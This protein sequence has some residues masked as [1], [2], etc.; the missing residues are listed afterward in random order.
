MMRVTMKKL[1]MAAALAALAGSAFAAHER[2]QAVKDHLEWFKDQKFGL[3]MHFGLYSQLGIVESWPLV[4]ADASWSRFEIANMTGDALRSMYFGMNRSFNPVLFDPKEWADAAVAGGFKYVIFTTKHHDGFCLY[5]TKYTDFKTTDASC[6][7]SSNANANLVKRLFDACR[8]RGL[9]I[10][11]YFSKADWHCTDYWENHGIGYH[12]TR[13]PTYDPRK[14]PVKWGRFRDFT[15]NQMVELARDCG[16]LDM[17]WLDAGWCGP[18]NNQN[19][20][21]EGTMAE[22]RKYSPGVLAIGLDSDSPCDDVKVV[23][24]KLPETAMVDQAWESCRKTARYWSYHYDLPYRTSHEIIHELVEIVAKGGNLALNIGP[25]PNGKLPE[26]ALKVTREI[27]AWLKVN[28][29]AI[30]ATRPLAPYFKDKWG[31]TVSKS[32]VRYAIRI[33]GPED[34]GLSAV[35]VAADSPIAKAW[36]IRNLR[37]SRGMSVDKAADGTFEIKL[38]DWFK[39]DADADAFELL[40]K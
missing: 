23:E 24:N 36:A 15:R 17:F 8:A 27:G 1:M 35:K 33:W 7:Y 39:P 29:T 5:D 10:S 37:T 6:P 4:D 31:Y 12:T 20:D 22:C 28:G 3:F 13:H 25:M 2:P 9:G 32:G 38:P 40:I 26:Q 21:I 19:I 14:D 34:K 11:A 30:Y 16:P 18:A